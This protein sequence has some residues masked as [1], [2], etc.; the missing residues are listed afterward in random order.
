LTADQLVPEE[1][2][3]DGWQ[4]RVLPGT[5]LWEVPVANPLQ[6][7]TAVTLTSLNNDTTHKTIDTFIGGEAG[8]FLLRPDDHSWAFQVDVFGLSLSRW[9]GE[10]ESVAADYRF[11]FPLTFGCG[12]WEAKVGYEHTSTHLGDQFVELTGAQHIGNVR[13]EVVL[14]LAYRFWDDFR[15]YGIFGYPLQASTSS[16]SDTTRF[17]WGLEWVTPHATGVRGKP[18]A[19]FDMELRHEQDYTPNISAQAGW[20]WRGWERG[21]MVRA[22]VEFY[23]GD[24]IFGQFYRVHEQYVGVG[25]FLDF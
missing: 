16:G 22:A 8:L 23:D 4:C 20:M 2:A 5:H 21:S 3:E 12:N 9:A 24:S 11:G 15:V 6:P 10:R 19:A 18:F 13:D 1:E 17:D 14:G 7:R 25:L